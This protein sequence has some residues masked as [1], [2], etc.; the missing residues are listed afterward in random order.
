MRY[1]CSMYTPTRGESVTVQS[2]NVCATAWM[3]TKVVM[4]MYTACD[5][6][7][8]SSVMR[9]KKD[10]TRES[11]T[12]PVAIKVYNE[13]M[14]GVDR[15]DQ[16]RGYYHVRMKCRKIY[17]YIYN[18]LFD[19]AITNAYI[20]Y[21]HCH[22]DSKVKIKE[23]RVQLANELIGEYCSRTT[24]GHKR[25]KRLVMAHF[26]YMNE[27]RK[28]G[29]CSLCK[30]NKKRVDTIWACTECGVWLCHPGTS[31]DC[32]ARWHSRM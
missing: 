16:L 19:V 10:G 20:I 2:D 29:R 6:T 30:E 18:F 22:P 9:R 3:D 1:L 25:Q 26:P 14:G 17:K 11:I 8:S 24:V 32:F 23:F 5:P 28:R 12:C 13:K 7:K 15:G 21:H 31:D 4:A 27:Q